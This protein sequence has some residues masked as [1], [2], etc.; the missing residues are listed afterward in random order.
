M[1]AAILGFL[2]SADVEGRLKK[3]SGSKQAMALR[4]SRRG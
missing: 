2:E 4:K 3:R 1:S